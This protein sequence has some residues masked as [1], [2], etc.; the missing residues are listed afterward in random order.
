[1]IQSKNAEANTVSALGQIDVNKFV[2]IFKR[3]GA[4]RVLFFGNSITRHEPNPSLGWYGDWGM[5]ASSKDKDYVHLVVA[6][7]DKKFGKVD[8]CIAQGAMWEWGYRNAPEVLKEYYTEVKNFDPHIIVIRIGENITAPKHLEVNCKP[9]FAEAVD[10]LVGKS[11]EK[12]IITDMFWYAIYNDCFKEVCEE[13]GYTFCHLTD[14]ENDERT[15]A[16][17]LFEH[18]GVAS[19]PGD[20]GMQCIAERILE[21]IFE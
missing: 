10:F 5:A 18:K 3:G 4:K 21:K 2:S 15:M 16:K 19:H 14:L 1:M 11:A 9:H 13:K 7:L 6:E 17:G 8:Y 20:F 12:V